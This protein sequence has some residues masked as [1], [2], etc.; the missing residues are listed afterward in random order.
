MGRARH[1]R[2]RG[3]HR[4]SRRRPGGGAASRPPRHRRARRGRVGR[5]HGVHIP[6]PGTLHR[7]R[8]GGGGSS[9]GHRRGPLVPRAR[10]AGAAGG[11]TGSGGP[12]RL[13]RSL[14]PAARRAAGDRAAAAGGRRAGGRPRRRQLDGR[15]RGGLPGRPRLVRQER[16]PPAAGCRQ[17]VRARFGGH[18]GRVRTGA[19]TGGRRVRVVPALH[20]RVPDRGDRR[21][22]GDRRQPMPGLGAAAAGLDPR[23]AAGRGRRSRLRLRRL[24]GRLPAHG[25]PRAPAHGAAR[26]STS[27]R[28]WTCSTCST[29]TTRRCSQRHGRWYIAGRDPRWLRRNALVV[30]GNVGVADDPRTLATLARYRNGPDALL[31][32]H[33][34]WASERLA[35]RRARTS[36]AECRNVR[37][38]IPRRP[39]PSCGVKTRSGPR[40]RTVSFEDRCGWTEQRMKHLLVT[41]DYPPKI[42]GIQTLLW[43]WWRRL[44]PSAF[45]VLTSPYRGA[46]AFDA[47]QAYR[48]ERVPEK[49]LLPHPIMV[50]RIDELA[51]DFGADFVVL[52]PA[53]P[54]GLVGPSLRLPYDVVLHGAEVTVP[55]RLPGSKQ[56]LGVGPAW[57]PPHRLGRGVRRAGGRAGRRP[58][59]ADHGRPARRRHRALPPARRRRTARGT[60]SLRPAARR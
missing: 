40:R 5:G 3:R 20:R 60:P 13:D 2:S 49:V 43:E 34:R 36:H 37:V 4:A 42:G 1:A 35:S 9:L 15:P 58:R 33:A 38:V 29:P 16:Q 57:R 24:P 23:G 30:L 46:A 41:N 51:A 39:D 55:G 17:L 26:G 47:E 54:L 59:A 32:E 31:A 10:A 56:A 50:R 25:A 45:A 27:R 8:S 18:H 52:D 11:A 14:R 7:S 22:R 19:A 12:L 6:Q 21:A 28:G 48:I 53:V 44:P